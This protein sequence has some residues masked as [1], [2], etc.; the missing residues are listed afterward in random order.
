MNLYRIAFKVRPTP[1]HPNY[2][3]MAY[4]ILHL[5]LFDDNRTSVIE[6]ASAIMAQ[7]PY[8]VVGEGFGIW[9]NEDKTTAEQLRERGLELLTDNIVEA[10][11]F[12]FSYFLMAVKIGED[13]VEEFIK[14]KFE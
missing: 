6:R 2:W 13:G 8:E 12:G 1:K 7:F 11:K 14:A 3:E 10:S 9:V 4:G 5:I